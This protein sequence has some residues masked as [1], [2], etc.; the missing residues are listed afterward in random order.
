MRGDGSE[1]LALVTP[2]S[3]DCGEG[4]RRWH[5]LSEPCWKQT[6]GATAAVLAVGSALTHH[7]KGVPWLARD[8][9][10]LIP[11]ASCGLVHSAQAWADLAL[12]RAALETASVGKS[13]K[14]GRL[15]QVRQF[16]W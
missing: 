6:S 11:D 4:R 16:G 12:G 13:V 15:Q 10:W 7:L 8:F 14:A 9:V 3:V 5:A 2:V 1:A